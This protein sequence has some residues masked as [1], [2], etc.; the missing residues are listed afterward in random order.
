MARPY[1]NWAKLTVKSQ[2]TGTYQPFKQTT[3]DRYS[4]GKEPKAPSNA[5]LR[6]VK[7]MVHGAPGSDPA[8]V[9]KAVSGA[10]L[11]LEGQ[12]GKKI[13]LGPAFLRTKECNP[14]ANED[15]YGFTIPVEIP[16]GAEYNV[17]VSFEKAS[18]NSADVD[19]FIEVEGME[20]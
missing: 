12:S 4:L 2:T 1:V 5:K 19:L 15:A 6:I 8:E 13:D 20:V 16:A 10:V 11:I 14:W 9:Q 17:I 7:V 18:A 3:S